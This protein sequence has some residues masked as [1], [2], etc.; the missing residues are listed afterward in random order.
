[1]L[2]SDR[3]IIADPKVYESSK[4]NTETE[5]EYVKIEG[6]MCFEQFRRKDPI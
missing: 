1:M 2:V 6:K 3:I 4:K 5:A